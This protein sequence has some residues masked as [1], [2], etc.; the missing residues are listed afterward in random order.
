MSTIP[1]D[2]RGELES[3]LDRAIDQLATGDDWRRLNGLLAENVALQSL[4][5]AWMRLHGHLAW[6]FSPPQELSLDELRRFSLADSLA[7][8]SSEAAVN[9]ATLPRKRGSL[10]SRGWFVGHRFSLAVAVALIVVGAIGGMFW[11]ATSGS[12]QTEINNREAVAGSQSP[13]AEGTST[14]SGG[15]TPDGGAP[16]AVA[17]LAF[18][19]D[20]KWANPASAPAAGAALVVGR[21]LKLASGEAKVA[22]AVGAE[23]TLHGPASFEVESAT[24]GFLSVGQ[25]HAR[26]AAPAARGFAIHSHSASATDLGTEFDMFIAADGHCQIRVANGAVEVRTG[27]EQ[28]RLRLDEGQAVAIEPDS[29]SIFAL[30]ESGDGTAAFRFP[31]IAPPSNN[32][33]ADVSQHHATINVLRGQ[34]HSGG[35]SLEVLIDGK[36]QSKP[37]SPGESFSFDANGSGLILLDLGRKIAVEKINTYS[38]HGDRPI[39]GNR[40]RATQRYILYGS[41]A[42]RPPSV[43]GNLA[44]NGWSCIAHVNTDRFSGNSTPRP[45]AAQQGVSIAATNGALGA[46]RYLLWDGQP[47]GSDAEL[48]NDRTLY[49]EF[50]V[51]GR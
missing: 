10:K 24:S 26:I 2:C 33:Y 44:T 11:L 3:I 42:E 39:T 37:G 48:A 21:K 40:D 45:R 18:A 30:I 22:F 9:L 41:S 29:P 49:G 1:P 36:G 47:T 15:A 19:A 38:W 5:V 6:H 14:N 4:Y 12:R 7:D 51:F 43:M 13:K 8:G 23:V 32:D 17:R 35:G 25:L 27:K 28:R 50:D 31:T 20:C 34:V 46:Y 16:A